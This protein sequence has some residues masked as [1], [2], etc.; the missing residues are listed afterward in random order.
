MANRIIWSPRA[1]S[2]L[3]SV[4]EFI[5]EDSPVYACIFAQKVVALV[6][7]IPAFPQTGRMV[8]EYNN[9]HLRERIYGD[10]RIIYRIQAK[11]IEIVALCHGARQLERVLPKSG[12]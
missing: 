7:S 1:A 6:K 12:E 8:P 10:Y 5:A 3:E 4:C 11:H 2:H 9:P